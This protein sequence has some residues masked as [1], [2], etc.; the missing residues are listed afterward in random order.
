M[1]HD[2]HYPCCNLCKCL[3]AACESAGPAET[4]L[5]AHVPRSSDECN[6]QDITRCIAVWCQRCWVI[7]EHASRTSCHAC[8]SDSQHHCR[9]PKLPAPGLRQV[10]TRLNHAVLSWRANWTPRGQLQL[11]C[12]R[13]AMIMS[14]AIHGFGILVVPAFHRPVT[15]ADD[16]D[17]CESA[18]S[19]CFTT[20]CCQQVFS[21]V[22]QLQKLPCRSLYQL[23][24][25]HESDSDH[26]AL[27]LLAFNL[28][29]RTVLMGL[30]ADTRCA[31]QDGSCLYRHMPVKAPGRQLQRPSWQACSSSWTPAKTHLIT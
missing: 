5:A 9:K 8:M 1:A 18:A 19:I 28:C 3:R 14:I 25:M 16:S 23:T 20:C 11:P 30:L 4:C 6:V 15:C 10:G 12:A 26:K 22:V 24:C 27:L 7:S 13:S 2:A 17:W 21:H 29:T 31:C